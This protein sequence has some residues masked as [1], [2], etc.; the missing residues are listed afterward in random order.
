MAGIGLPRLLDE[1][2]FARRQIAREA[3]GSW[4]VIGS[5]RRDDAGQWYNS[6]MALDGEGEIAAIYDKSRLVPFGEYQPRFLPFNIM[7]GNFGRPW[8]AHMAVAEVGARRAARLLRGC[9]FPAR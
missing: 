9:F 3:G 1:A 4:G 7:P 8:A 5:D 2:P 6:A